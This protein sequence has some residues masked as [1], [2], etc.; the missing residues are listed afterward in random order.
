MLANS[1]ISIPKAEYQSMRDRIVQLQSAVTT[2]E[3]RLHGLADNVPGMIYQ[4]S[5]NSDGTM[6]IPYVSSGCQPI[7]EL[8]PQQI[9]QQREIMFSMLHPDDEAQFQQTISE[10]A[11]TL[12]KWE[13]QWRII[14]PSGKEKWLQGFSQPQIQENGSILWYGCVIDITKRKQAEIDLAQ[15]NEQLE[16]KIQEKTAQL[17]ASQERLQRLADKVPGMLYE[18]RLDE[19]NASL[20]YVSSGSSLIFELQ[21]EEIQQDVEIINRQIH[22]EDF[23]KVTEA[24]L[25]SAQTLEQWEY[26]WRIT[27]P[28]GKQKWIQG[29]SQPT[30]Q[31]D[32]SILWYG[33]F[34]DV[35]KRQQVETELRQK[36][37]QYRNIFETVSDGLF[38]CDLETGLV[39][40]VNPAA[41]ELYDYS[42]EEFIGIHPTKFIHPCHYS[43]FESFLQTISAGESFHSHAITSRK[44]GS[45]LD[46]DVK[47]S[48]CIYNGKPHALSIV[49]DITQRQLAEEKLQKQART[50]KEALHKLRNTQAKLVQSEK[51]SSLGQMV[52]GVAH[53]INNPVNFIHGNLQ[54]ATEYVQDLLGLLELYQQFYP[55][56]HPEIQA[57]IETIEL[58]FLQKD[59][60]K[61]LNSMQEGTKRIREIVLSLRN[62]SRLDEA[63]FKK[64]NI[65]QGIDSTLMIL[66]NRL[67][68]KPSFPEIQ[69]IKEYDILPSIQCYPGQL[70]QVFMNILV[71][72]IDA[73][74]DGIKNGH[75]LLNPQ[76][77]INTKLIKSRY[78]KI[79]IADNG[80]GIPPNIQNKLFDPFFTTKEVGK[81]T[82]LGLSIS[83]Q[84]VVEKHRGKLYCYSKPGKGTEFVIEIPI[85]QVKG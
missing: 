26:S 29:I 52:A 68:A 82:G 9:Q 3:K 34:I 41:C 38:I 53:E 11:Q 75:K 58:D 65:H 73:L 23:P 54:P 71:N 12:R 51:M 37:Q 17:Q 85:L 31:E 42:Q 16:A 79:S 13:L 64:A 6:S 57:E 1:L 72:A 45:R 66:N 44:D 18:Y 27:T 55:Q 69:I 30:L 61:I 59:L 81:G 35:T 39:V 43:L 14:T 63:D 25:K 48:Q 49:R 77:T 21:P 19:R 74:E 46:V 62:F 20:P 28:S 50:L 10:S 5:L 33:C 83:Y 70:N 60:T 36:E 84:I 80:C 67:K 24:I 76:I 32:G 78:I 15:L 40:T 56:P 2:L 22:P 7:Y 47:G 8:E 4:F